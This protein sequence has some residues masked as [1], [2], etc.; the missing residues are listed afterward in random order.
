MPGGRVLKGIPK[1]GG[2]VRCERFDRTLYVVLK[3]FSLRFKRTFLK[4]K[5]GFDRTVL[6]GLIE[7]F[8]G[9]DR[10]FLGR[11]PISR[12]FFTHSKISAGFFNRV[13]T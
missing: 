6:D 12:Y 7:P 8:E 9:F 5:R 1:R 13:G 4:A 10:T 11:S 3:S 2:G